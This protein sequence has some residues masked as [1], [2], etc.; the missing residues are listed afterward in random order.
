M[1]QKVSPTGFRL[2]ITEDWRS[3]WYAGKNYAE[4]LDNDLAIRKY[5]EKRLARAAVA[6][7]EIE[8]AGDKVKIIITTARPTVVI[9]KKGSEIEQLRKE[10]AEFVDGKISV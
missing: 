5:L 3:R 4:L 10:L 9:G 1:G 7:I 8:R 2:G 6:K